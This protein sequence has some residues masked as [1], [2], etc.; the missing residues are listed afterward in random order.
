MTL[1]PL[2][3][4][5]LIKLLDEEQTTDSG[6]ILPDEVKKRQAKGK[7][8]RTGDCDFEIYK[9]IREQN[10]T[11]DPPISAGQTVWFKRFAGEEIKDGSENLLFV[12]YQDILGVYE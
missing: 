5:C 12:S 4:F 3:G 7:V 1:K 8:I 9:F 6:F 2:R 11:W 10:L